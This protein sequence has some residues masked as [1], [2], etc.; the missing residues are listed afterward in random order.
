MLDHEYSL[1]TE[2]L[3]ATRGDGSS[4]FAFADTVSARNYR[5]SNRCHGWMGIRFQPVPKS[6]PNDIVMHIRMLD[7][8]NILQQEA[9]GIL[10]LNVLYGAYHLATDP[11]AFIRSLLDELSPGRIDVDVVEFTGPAFADFDNRE[12][13]LKLLQHGLTDG[14]LF[15]ENNNIV[16][17]MSELR[18]RPVLIQRGSFRPVTHVNVDIVRAGKAQ[19]EKDNNGGQ[20]KPL[21]VLEMTLKNLVDQVGNED[22]ILKLTESLTVL[23]V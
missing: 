21:V 17:P 14:V 18:K 3:K 11:D 12:M 5:G 8:A 22:T 16:Q 10:G 9:I 15:D 2:R 13:S 4:F 7:N 1:I 6:E 19:F 20:N 23:G